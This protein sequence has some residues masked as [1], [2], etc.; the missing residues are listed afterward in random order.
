[1]QAYGRNAQEDSIQFNGH[2]RTSCA[3]SS[4]KLARRRRKRTGSEADRSPRRSPEKRF[5]DMKGAMPK[6][7]QEKSAN[8]YVQNYLLNKNEPTWGLI[9][10]IEHLYAGIT[11]FPEGRGPKYH[12]LCAASLLCSEWEEV[13]HAQIKHQHIK[14]RLLLYCRMKIKK[15]LAGRPM[16]PFGSVSLFPFFCIALSCVS[17]HWDGWR[18]ISTPRLKSLRTLYLEPIHRLRVSISGLLLRL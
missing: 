8:Q 18:I 13:V 6:V 17:Q 15:A 5:R 3:P 12:R 11:Y 14:V 9:W 2:K 7:Y 16:R 10:A 4:P 1:M